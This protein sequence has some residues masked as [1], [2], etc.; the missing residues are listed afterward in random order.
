MKLEKLISVRLRETGDDVRQCWSVSHRHLTTV[1]ADRSLRRRDPTFPVEMWT[2][3]ERSRNVDSRTNNYVEAAHKS[4]KSLFGVDHPSL[5]RFIE[6]IRTHQRTKDAEL[7]RYIAGHIVPKKR[8]KYLENDK[9]IMRILANVNT[10][11]AI[12]SL[13]AIAHTYEMNP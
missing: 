7:E 11:E 6:G 12:V 2:V 3:F 1:E 13:R 4:L 8:N 5:L 10:N 9:R